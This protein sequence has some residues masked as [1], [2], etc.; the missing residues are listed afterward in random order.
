LGLCE[1]RWRYC[2]ITG[3]YTCPQDED[4]ADWLSWFCVDP[5]QRGQGIGGKLLAFSI[6]EARG[7]GKQ[8]LRLYTSDDPNEAEAQGL[9][10]K[11]GLRVVREEKVRTHTLIYRELRL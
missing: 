10:E 7:R 8:F 2:G 6:E 4:E 1:W 9:Y 3:L 5:A 11:F